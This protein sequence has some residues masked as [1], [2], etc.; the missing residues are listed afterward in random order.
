MDRSRKNCAMDPR[1]SMDVWVFLF[2]NSCHRHTTVLVSIVP[3]CR[4]QCG[5]DLACTTDQRARSPW[6]VTWYIDSYCPNPSGPVPL[7]LKPISVE[8]D[9][10]VHDKSC[11]RTDCKLISN[12]QCHDH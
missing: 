10:L 9:K 5:F 6:L 2:F 8:S 7:K 3:A 12:V 11:M 1:V 4:R